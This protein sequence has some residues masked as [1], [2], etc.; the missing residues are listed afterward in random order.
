VSKSPWHAAAINLEAVSHSHVTPPAPPEKANLPAAQRERRGDGV[1]ARGRWG[2]PRATVA[3][4]AEAG[5]FPASAP[6]G[7][8]AAHATRLC[9]SR[10]GN[11]PQ[12]QRAVPPPYPSRRISLPSENASAAETEPATES[13]S[14]TGVWS[15]HRSE[16]AAALQEGDDINVILGWNYRYFKKWVNASPLTEEAF[17]I[18]NSFVWSYNYLGSEKAEAAVGFSS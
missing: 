8:R 1:P 6:A 15:G 13:V 4:A 11:S 3:G 17:L 7:P 2:E 5:C 18:V 12:S 16:D 9:G 14:A 10:E